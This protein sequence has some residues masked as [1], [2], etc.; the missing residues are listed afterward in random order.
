MFYESEAHITSVFSLTDIENSLQIANVILLLPERE[1]MYIYNLII[2]LAMKSHSKSYCM[3]KHTF[4][5]YKII[6]LLKAV[7]SLYVRFHIYNMIIL[8]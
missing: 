3:L 4:V 2:R 8:V 7:V 6:V 1:K 5:C